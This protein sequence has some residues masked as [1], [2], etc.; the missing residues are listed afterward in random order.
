MFYK[1]LAFVTL[2]LALIAVETRGAYRA[3]NGK[4]K[5]QNVTPFLVAIVR[6]DEFVEKKS[7]AIELIDDALQEV[8]KIIE[9]GE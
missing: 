9:K 2:S 7:R 8:S 3:N 1:Q 4:T 6:V 5:K